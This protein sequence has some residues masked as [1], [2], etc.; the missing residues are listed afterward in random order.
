MTT[1]PN[2]L[3]DGQHPAYARLNEALFVAGYNSDLEAA[4]THRSA[5]RVAELAFNRSIDDMLD[6]L[7]ERVL[8]GR[9][10]RFGELEAEA[11]RR[12]PDGPTP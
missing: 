10:Q 7:A 4:M 2:T 3:E 12:E 6:D 1:E 9:A 11:G 8:A 5:R